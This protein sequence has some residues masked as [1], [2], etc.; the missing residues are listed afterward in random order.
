LQPHIWKLLGA[1]VNQEDFYQTL[2]LPSVTA[3][4]GNMTAWDK[5]ILPMLSFNLK[6]SLSTQANQ[7]GFNKPSNYLLL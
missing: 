5:N 3:P 2:L 4:L 1:L 6:R 7:S